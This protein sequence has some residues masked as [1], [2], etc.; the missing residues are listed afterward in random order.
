MVKMVKKYIFLL[1][2]SVKLFGDIEVYFQEDEIEYIPKHLIAVEFLV[3][4]ISRSEANIDKKDVVHNRSMSGA[5]IKIGAED[6]GLRLFLSYRTIDI[7]GVL[8]YSY[9]LEIDSLITTESIWKFFYGAHVGGICYKFDGEN[10]YKE[11]TS[12]YYGL[13]LGVIAELSNSYDFEVGAR[14]SLTHPEKSSIS[15]AYVVDEILN[16]YIALNFKY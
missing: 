6:M 4:S 9:G 1:L 3:G 14:Y 11:K 10:S 12:P 8:T 5:G 16:Y 15:T 7:K 2:F 13:E